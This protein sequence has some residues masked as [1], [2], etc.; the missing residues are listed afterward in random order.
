VLSKKSFAGN[1]AL[2]IDITKAFDTLDWNF[3][4]SIL[5]QFASI[6]SFA[7]GLKKF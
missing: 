7:P 5:K 1:L 6:T 2:K 4:L 3:L